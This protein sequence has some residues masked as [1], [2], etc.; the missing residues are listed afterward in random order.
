MLTLPCSRSSQ[1]VTTYAVR[2]QV[3]FELDDEGSQII[4][5]VLRA[6]RG[7]DAVGTS[8]AECRRITAAAMIDIWHVSSMNSCFVPSTRLPSWRI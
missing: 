7:P 6:M 3:P 8:P 5:K 1:K 4:A 2:V